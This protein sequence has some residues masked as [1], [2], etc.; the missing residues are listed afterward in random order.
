MPHIE[1]TAPGG[2]SWVELNTTDQNAAKTFYS[3]LFGWEILDSP[4]GPD[5]VYTMFS[6]EGRNTGAAATLRPEMKAAGVPP[7]WL[8]YINVAS[9]DESTEKVK[10][11]GGQ[12]FM[13]PF[14]VM[15]YGRMS[16]VA[17]PAGAS[18][19]LWEDRDHSGF[20][21]TGVPGTLCWAD[22][23]TRDVEGASKFYS[24]VFGW[25]LIKDGRAETGTPEY[26][27]IQNG[28]EMIGGMPPAEQ[29]PPG[30]P[31]HW[32]IYF[33]VTD[34][35]ASTEKAKALGATVQMG[36]INIPHVG[37]MCLVAD[38]QGA[39]FALFTPEKK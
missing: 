1:K 10:A 21:I 27:H 35:A 39:S 3:K 34:C 7:H 4:M 20:G 26:L 37:D 19:C 31:A 38:P 23:R 22:L 33:Y 5:E 15:T 8:L 9:A 13:G 30:V 12:V 28:E 25:K 18:F 14:D 6:L 36:P 11:A 17:D 32:G 16:A 2:F 24:D 29:L